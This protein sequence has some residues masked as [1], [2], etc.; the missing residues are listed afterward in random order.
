[1]SLRHCVDQQVLNGE[2]ERERSDGGGEVLK[3]FTRSGI[4]AGGVR[5]CWCWCCLDCCLGK[6]IV[7]EREENDLEEEHRDLWTSNRERELTAG[8]A[9]RDG[10]VKKEIIELT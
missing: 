7:G 9:R 2:G 6:Y 8:E 1:M 4:E 10:N 3:V 5:N